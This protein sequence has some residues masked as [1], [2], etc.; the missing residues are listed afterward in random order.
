ML[1]FYDVRVQQRVAGFSSSE[2]FVLKTPE[3]FAKEGNSEVR[4]AK[5][6]FK[7]SKLADL[8]HAYPF[9]A[10][11]TPGEIVYEQERRQAFLHFLNGL[12]V[13]DPAARWTAREALRHP[14]ITG[15]HFVDESSGEREE[16]ILHSQSG[17]PPSSCYYQ[18][19]PQEQGQ[20]TMQYAGVPHMAVM[21]YQQQQQM[22][23]PQR[24]C[25][26]NAYYLDAS[27]PY[28]NGG[29]PLSSYAYNQPWVPAYAPF[30]MGDDGN[31]VS[32][33]SNSLQQADYEYPSQLQS[34][35]CWDVPPC[36]V[37]T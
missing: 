15:E 34:Q 28:Y 21:R 3:Q 33:N 7:Y 17:S 24:V 6:Y 16:S 32:N 13:V 1:K 8:V 27:D 5:K 14:F 22:P 26:I 2:E 4:I 19:Q 29:E 12:L 9:R 18:Q 37:S 20:S 10:N 31:Y 23:I 30:S 36:E 35:F 11:A 25:P